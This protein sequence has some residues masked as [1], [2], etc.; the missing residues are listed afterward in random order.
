MRKGVD[1]EKTLPEIIQQHAW[2]LEN[3]DTGRRA[4]LITPIALRTNF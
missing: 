3:Y 1:V 2:L 4:E